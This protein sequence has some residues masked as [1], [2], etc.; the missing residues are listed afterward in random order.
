MEG[1]NAKEKEDLNPDV[2]GILPNFFSTMGIPIVMGH[3]FTDRDTFG[4]PKV[5]IVNERFANY[6][7]H[8]RNPIGRQIGLA[9]RSQQNSMWRSLVL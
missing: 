9:L 3:E 1:Y 4:A 8:D 2:K 6:F 7:F 5:A